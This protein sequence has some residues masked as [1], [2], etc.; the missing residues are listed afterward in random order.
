MRKIRLPRGYKLQS[1]IGPKLYQGAARCNLPLYTPRLIFFFSFFLLFFSVY[2][3]D[4]L[5]SHQLFFIF[6]DEGLACELLYFFLIFRAGLTAW[7]L[8]KETTPSFCCCCCCCRK[9]YL[10]FFALTARARCVFIKKLS[11]PGQLI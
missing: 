1:V 4:F 5:F 3:P 11:M 6:F 9:V 2:P 8:D 10:L 7:H